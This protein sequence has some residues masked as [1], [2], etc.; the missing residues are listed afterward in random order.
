MP[1]QEICDQCGN[2]KCSCRRCRGENRGYRCGFTGCWFTQTL[3]DEKC[4][5]SGLFKGF[6]QKEYVIPQDIVDKLANIIT[7][8]GMK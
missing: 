5:A 4:K 2:E 6:I 3:P 8:G 1:K 7:Q